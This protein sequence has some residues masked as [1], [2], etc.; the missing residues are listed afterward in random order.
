MSSLKVGAK[1]CFPHGTRLLPPQH[2]PNAVRRW[3][4]SQ[5]RRERSVRG[6]SATQVI[7]QACCASEAHWRAL[8]RITLKVPSCW[9][10][11]PALNGKPSI[12]LFFFPVTH[13]FAAIFRPN[14]QTKDCHCCHF[15][16]SCFSPL[17]WKSC[18]YSHFHCLGKHNNFAQEKSF[19]W[20]TLHPRGSRAGHKTAGLY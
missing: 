12:G 18:C 19:A 5:T 2:A 16:V 14:F 8:Q 10:K 1:L 17:S 4:R 3:W 9:T 20:Q 13:L 11:S 15:G 7:C 6:C